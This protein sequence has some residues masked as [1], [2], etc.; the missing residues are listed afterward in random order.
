MRKRWLFSVLATVVLAIGALGG[1]VLAQ[2]AG[3]GDSAGAPAIS[4]A[5][6]GV[7]ERVA[8]KLGIAEDDLRAAFDEAKAELN[9]E[10]IVARIDAMVE[11]GKLTPEEGEELLSWSQS[12][13]DV[14][15][16]NAF[17]R[18]GHRGFGHGFGRG[19]GGHGSHFFGGPRGDGGAADVAPT[20]DAV[21]A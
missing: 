16:G 18:R 4:V 1:T 8:G 5:G 21:S 20:G 14:L 13:P 11:S 9:D 19:F 7:L 10:R 6:G 2:D 17:G 15:E 3:S 12:R